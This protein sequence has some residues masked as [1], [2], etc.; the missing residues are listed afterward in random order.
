MRGG[1]DDSFMKTTE[2]LKDTKIRG[3]DYPVDTAPPQRRGNKA[4]R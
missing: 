4:G 1:H 3:I 2:N